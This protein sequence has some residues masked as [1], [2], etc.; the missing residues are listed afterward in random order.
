VLVALT[1]YHGEEDRLQA[2]VAGFDHH[3]LKPFPPGDLKDLLAVA[4]SR[5]GLRERGPVPCTLS[6][7][8]G[9]FEGGA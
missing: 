3:L 9:V 4:A 1:G 8:S 6:P 5:K 2:R 7:R